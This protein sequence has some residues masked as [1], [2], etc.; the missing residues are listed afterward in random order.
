MNKKAFIIIVFLVIL[1]FLFGNKIFFSEK[2]I[3]PSTIAISDLVIE[4]EKVTMTADLINSGIGFTDYEYK[5][6]GDV[7]VITFYGKLIK[8]EGNGRINVEIEENISNFD[9]IM[10]A[11]TEESKIIWEKENLD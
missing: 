5:L 7:L 4:E 10:I 11:T 9:K 2:M 8:D 1:L 3:E 6:D